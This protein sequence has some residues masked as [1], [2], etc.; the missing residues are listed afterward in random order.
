MNLAVVAAHAL[1]IALRCLFVV[2]DVRDL[3]DG[4]DS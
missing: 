3:L 1:T 2:A 4:Q